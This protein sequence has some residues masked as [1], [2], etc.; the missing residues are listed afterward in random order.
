M[1][2][3]R[4]RETGALKELVY[5][6]KLW[7]WEPSALKEARTRDI[8]CIVNE[9]A[10]AKLSI[11]VDARMNEVVPMTLTPHLRLFLKADDGRKGQEVVTSGSGSMQSLALDQVVRLLTRGRTYIRAH[12]KMI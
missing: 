2:P 12:A 3:S 9:L 6:A 8:E 1:P 11:A 10:D 7:I 4:R 5:S